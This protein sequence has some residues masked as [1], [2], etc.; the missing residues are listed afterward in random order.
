MNERVIGYCPVNELIKVNVESF[1]YLHDA[2]PRDAHLVVDLRNC[3]HNPAADP[4]MRELTGLYPRVR[5]HVLDTPGT[6]D[7]LASVLETTRVLHQ[8]HNP[9]R[10]KV[11]VAFG[12]AGGRHRS[13][14]LANELT[15][16]LNRAGIAT[17]VVHRDILQPVVRDNR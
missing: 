5:Q 4:A 8:L 14:V 9:R 2:P 10:R 3:L 1:G 6:A 13:V 16:A 15:N 11:I 7:V 12:C 17:S